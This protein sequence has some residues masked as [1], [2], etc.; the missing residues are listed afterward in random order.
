MKLIKAGNTYCNVEDV[1]RIEEIWDSNDCLR[2]RIHFNKENGCPFVIDIGPF[3]NRK[4]L[5]EAI[6]KFLKMTKAEIY[7]VDGMY[8]GF[9]FIQIAGFPRVYFD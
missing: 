5:E 6:D 2:F 8:E 4:R 1:K 9:D 7:S 3:E